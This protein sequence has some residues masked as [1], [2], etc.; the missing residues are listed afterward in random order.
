MVIFNEA[1]HKYFYG[2][3]E[4]RSV[5]S[6]FKPFEGFDR[7]SESFRMALK[8][9][10]PDWY[11][12]LS[13]A[14]GY[15]SA[16][17][18]TE[19]I[20]IYSVEEV[21]ELQQQILAEWS[22]T[23]LIATTQGTSFHKA[24]EAMDYDRGGRQNPFTDEWHP[25]VDIKIKGYDNNSVDFLNDLQDGYYP[26]LLIFNHEKKLA[27][28]ADMVFVK[29][30]KIWIDDW[31]TDKKIE[32]KSF[33]TKRYGYAFMRAPLDHV[34]DCNYWRYALKISTYAWMLEEAGFEVAE[35]G[36]THVQGGEEGGDYL[37][38]VP[39]LREEVLSLF[40]IENS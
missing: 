11:G 24:M 36:F 38:K 19:M 9:I 8:L 40:Q 28:T 30:G 23:A 1:P 35:L 31:K 13:R 21:Q 39:Y 10:D 16:K 29:D 34:F 3:T 12:E 22:E 32:T 2:D 15:K 5:S 33:Y 7:D 37:Y 4:Y 18:G 27:G 26:E 14:Y 6:L 17:I 25:L 20:G